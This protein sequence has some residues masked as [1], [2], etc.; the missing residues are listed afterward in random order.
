MDH[1][2]NITDSKTLREVFLAAACPTV[3]EFQ[4]EYKI[5]MLSWYLPDF[6]RW[7]HR[8][9][10]RDGKGINIFWNNTR[11]GSFSVKYLRVLGAKYAVAF[12]YQ[13]RG[14]NVVLRGITDYVRKVSDGLYLGTFNYSIAGKV[15][16]LGYFLMVHP[17][18][19]TLTVYSGIN[20]L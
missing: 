7:D 2:L 4:G 17:Y 14:N 6:S 20:R 11:W 16:F 9:S 10:I 12:D 8:K 1:L 19:P 13:E 18:S 5:K 15:C 3:E